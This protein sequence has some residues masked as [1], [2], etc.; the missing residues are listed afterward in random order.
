MFFTMAS[1]RYKAGSLMDGWAYIRLGVRT[2]LR[3]LREL[4]TY[5]ADVIQ[6]FIRDDRGHSEQVLM[7]K[8]GQVL[9][10]GA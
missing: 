1:E 10:D 2:A 7:G 3:M 9:D 8:G 5:M 4:R 6:E